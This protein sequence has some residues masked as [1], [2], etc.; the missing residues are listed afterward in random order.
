MWASP[1]PR[2]ARQVRE[3]CQVIDGDLT[4]NTTDSINLDELK[5]V[6]G[7]IRHSRYEWEP[8]EPEAEPSP[9]NFSSSTLEAVDGF[10][11]FSG[12]PGLEKIML[13]SLNMVEGLSLRMVE[14]LTHVDFTNLEYVGHMRWS[15]PSLKRLDMNGLRGFTPAKYAGGNRFELGNIGEIDSVDAFYKS[16]MALRPTMASPLAISAYLLMGCLM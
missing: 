5:T 1:M 12:V 4:I 8:E 7:N 13:P 9:F 2:D 6:R 14:S 11:A 15:T 3:A 10:L 16:P